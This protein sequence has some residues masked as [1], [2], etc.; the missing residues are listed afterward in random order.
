ML[1]TDAAINPGNSGG[2]LVNLEGEVIGINTAIATNNGAFQGVGFV[3]PSNLAKWVM[4]QLI[5][6]GSRRTCLSWASPQP[7]R[8]EERRGRGLP[9]QAGRGS[10]HRRSDAR[11][12][13][14]RSRP[15]NR[16]HHHRV[17]RH[18]GP[19]PPELLE[20]VE[21][22]TVG[23]HQKLSVLRDG[24][25]I[26]VDVTPKAMPSDLLTRA[27]TPRCR[28]DAEESPEE[29]ANSSLGI[30]VGELSAQMAKA[31]GMKKAEGV[32]ITKVDPDSVAA[33]KGLSEGMVILSVGKQ[34]VKSVAEFRAA[35]K[36]ESLDK[37]ILLL[38][39]TR[40]GGNHFV[41]LQQAAE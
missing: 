5:K 11:F 32:V 2:P 10:H 7:T 37:G 34:S 24:K 39:R 26:A 40:S 14:R 29:Y 19:Q 41:V 4:G 20:L 3:I 15:A 33:E 31:L 36:N 21:R 28:P 12:A 13:G 9:R 38:V 6:K 16:R 27:R 8:G 23:S 18:Q 22:A 17:Q 1:Q 25:T 30:E 35:M